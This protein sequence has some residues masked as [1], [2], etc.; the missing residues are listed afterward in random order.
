M[1]WPLYSFFAELPTWATATVIVF[2]VFVLGYTGAGFLLWLVGAA[3]VLYG[4][5]AGLPA[6]IV[7]AAAFVLFGVPPVRRLI[8]GAIMSLLDRMGFLPTISK[9]EQEAI[10]A[11]T[12]WVEGELFSGRP[13][14]K[15]IMEEGYPDLTDEERAF[16]DGPTR[17]LCEMVD[18]WEVFER[19][20]LSQE[21]WDFMA[22][23]R[24]F[25]MIIPKEY[26]G[27]NFSASANSAV[28]GMTSATSAV[29]GI[30]VMV[31]N[32]LGPAE[33]LI[34]Y[35]TDEQKDYWLPRLAEHKEIPAFALTEPQAG[36]DAG[37]ISSSGVVFRGE[38]GRL[39]L[40]L[41]WKKRYITLAPVATVLGLAFKLHDPENLLGKGEDPGITCALVPTDTEGVDTSRRHDPMGIPF[42]NG[43][44]EGHDVVVDLER[45]IIGGADGA[46]RGWRML[47]ESLGAG[48]GISLPAVSTF[49]T[50][51]IARAAGAH[52]GIRK[53][54]G[55][56]I[57][58]FEGIEEP[59]A[60]I[61][62][63]AY[64]TEAARRY[65][66]GGLD[67][68]A[69]PPVVTAIMKYNTTELF[70]EA[71]N[72]GMDI[73]GGNAISLG[74][75]NTIGHAYINTPISITVE[76]AN[77]LT[78]TLMIF[79]QG[80]IRA[81]RYVLREVEAIQ[82][83]DKKAFDSA[84]WGHVGLVVQNFFRTVVLS[85][86]RGRVASSPVSGPAAR[87]FRKLAWAS[88]AF[89]LMSDIA[90]ATLGG[91]PKR[92]E[93]ITGRFADIFSWLY[94][95]AA[96]LRRFEAEGRREE[97]LPL[98]RWSMDEAFHRMQ[99]AFDGL[100][101]NLR[102]TGM[103]WL[104]HGPIGL[105]SRVNRFSSGA[106]DGDGHR[107]ARILQ[108]PGAQRDRLTS[109][110]H[111][112]AAEDRPLNR[113][114]RTLSVVTQTAE[115]DKRLKK[116]SRAGDIPREPLEE[117][118]DAAVRKG[119]LNESEAEL[120]REAEALRYDAITVDDF[121][122]EEYNRRSAIGTDTEPAAQHPMA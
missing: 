66:N 15:R 43:P 81:H 100:Y 85:V 52:A 34:H 96:T 64:I 21:V 25:S 95:A 76:G 44:T 71:V 19:R 18:D 83:K 114:E 48:R 41:N 56:P 101:A 55:L 120:V 11:G 27:L 13:N 1:N 57:G 47:M 59:L 68:G 63:Y 116:A 121:S 79:G 115:L 106:S 97:D 35:G 98:L 50:K 110:V 10:D 22:K 92:K 80:A 70:R 7:L 4:L 24:F 75:R 89:G 2:A 77:I 112:P 91:T 31:P 60:R 5:G 45:A 29:L 53:Q 42:Y 113:L 104:F 26:G 39:K 8:S 108:T 49:G 62:G 37:A 20:D 58:K 94:L 9:T 61:G 82:S 38:D 90:L 33:L 14:M 6:W 3:I 99:V 73:M 40:R 119:V 109:G 46:G 86:T 54:F 87:Y 84:F 16:V 78:R 93:K 107:V 117:Q 51:T 17:E 32:S 74:P 105:W 118:L 69:T 111:I 102:V 28:V 88:A 65:T 23:H 67:Q 36:S 30:T 122:Q 12:V 72:D 103:T